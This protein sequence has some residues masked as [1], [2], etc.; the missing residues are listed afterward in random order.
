MPS[1]YIPGDGFTASERIITKPRPPRYATEYTQPFAAAPGTRPYTA[2][3]IAS[4]APS[5]AAV[6]FSGRVVNVFHYPNNASSNGG[7]S[8]G[9]SPRA[10]TGCLRLILRGLDGTG[11]VTVRL[12]YADTAYPMRLGTRVAVWTTHVGISEDGKLAPP[13]A[14]LCASVFPERDRGCHV[15][16]IQEDSGGEERPRGSGETWRREAVKAELMTLERFAQGGFD[17]ERMGEVVRVVVCVKSVGVR[18]KARNPKSKAKEKKKRHKTKTLLTYSHSPP[19]VT[20][21]DNTPTTNLTVHLFDNTATEAT[22]TLWD[23][24]THSAAAW[25]PGRTILLLTNPGNRSNAAA[26]KLWLNLTSSSTVD[27]DP[28]VRDALWLRAYAARMRKRGHINPAFPMSRFA[29]LFSSVPATNAVNNANNADTK[30]NG[31]REE[32]KTILTPANCILHTLASLDAFA[33]R[34]PSV[35]LTGYLSVLL[36]PLNLVSLHQR[37]QL[38]SGQCAR[39]DYPLFANVPSVACPSCSSTS[40]PDGTSDLSVNNNNGNSYTGEQ[41]NGDHDYGDKVMVPLRLNP[42][43]IG[44]IHDET[45]SMTSGKLIWYEEAWAQLFGL[46]ARELATLDRETLRALEARCAWVRVSLFVGLCGEEGWDEGD[47]GVDEG[48]RERGAGKG[49]G[50]VG[51]EKEKGEEVVRLYVLG[52]SL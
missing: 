3:A 45:G 39:C 18:K 42:R 1:T 20:R 25:S 28:P 12:W 38:L 13:V 14:R 9:S 10:A 47:G 36:A 4:L 44:T 34:H 48:E 33:R 49:M 6:T 31:R 40:S 21:K 17:D 30:A 22:L 2:V 51:K 41:G 52:V 50:M 19:A 15:Q 16:V 37:G 11:L 23:Y 5:S 43:A 29:S 8:S 7:G 26:S 32:Q 46:C 24:S 27:V 35:T